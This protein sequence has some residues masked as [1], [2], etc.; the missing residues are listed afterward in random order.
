MNTVDIPKYYVLIS[1]NNWH[2]SAEIITVSTDKEK[3]EQFCKKL[4][5]QIDPNDA[6]IV[7]VKEFCDPFILYPNIEKMNFYEV[8]FDSSL[9]HI[10]TLAI[11]PRS[12]PPI[13]HKTDTYP[14]LTIADRRKYKSSGFLKTNDV[15]KLIIAAENPAIARKLAREKL[16]EYMEN[17]N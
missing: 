9:R 6:M 5:E 16:V 11:D 7:A 15:F 3:I 1:E 4:N 14:V 13:S 10:N 2:E 17:N 8:S 12:I